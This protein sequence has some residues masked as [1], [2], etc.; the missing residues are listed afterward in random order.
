MTQRVELENSDDN[1][2]FGCGPQNPMGL[3]LRFFMEGDRVI[4][5][6]IPTKWWSGQPGVVNPGIVY[7]VLVDLIIWTAGGILHRVPLMPKTIDMKLGDV[8]TRRP[9]S[10]I[11]WIVKREGPMAQIRA[12]LK[13]DGMVRALLEMETRSVT[14]AEYQ[15]ARP[16]VEIPASLTG[17]FEEES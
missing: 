11:G 14:R 16:M 6:C 3:K 7:A 17:F 10:G 9:I 2:C 5:E 13:Q 4:T 1:L 15:K 12:E 8:S